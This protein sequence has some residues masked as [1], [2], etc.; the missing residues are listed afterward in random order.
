[1]VII[2]FANDVN[3]KKDDD[4]NR[5]S[6]SSS[7]SNSSNN[8]DDDDDDNNNNNNNDDDNKNNN[9]NDAGNIVTATNSAKLGIDCLYLRVKGISKEE[10]RKKKNAGKKLSGNLVQTLMTY[11]FF[12]SVCEGGAVCVLVC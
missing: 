4:E 7:S 1:M 5:N 11:Y 8:N 9:N 6:S 3:N 2:T 12:A 10:T